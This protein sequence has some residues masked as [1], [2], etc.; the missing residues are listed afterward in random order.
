MAK[1]PIVSRQVRDAP[2]PGVRR[3]ATASPEAMG[4]GLGR[5]VQ[6]A[7][8]V[9]L[10]IHQDEQ[11]KAEQVRLF[12]LKRKLGEFENR[13]LYDAQNGALNARGEDAFGLPDQVLGD[14][15]T[16]VGE[17]SQG[18]GS[19]RL[20]QSFQE[21]AAGQRQGIDRTLQRHVG[22]EIQRHEAQTVEAVIANAQEAAAF[23][24][25]DPERVLDEID[26]QRAAII[27]QA[28]RN[29]LPGDWVKLKT[30]HAASATHIGVIS[31]MVSAGQD[32]EAQAYFDRFGDDIL[33]QG[34]QR[35]KAQD[36]IRRGN[37]LGT[38]QRIADDMLD[39]HDEGFGVGL[40][41]QEIR[42]MDLEPGA[43]AA[44]EQHVR[45]AFARRE[46]DRNQFREE[47]AN[48]IM[49]VLEEN[50][51]DMRVI[52][53]GLWDNLLPAQ[54]RGIERS[55]QEMTAPPEFKEGSANIAALDAVRQAIDIGRLQDPNTGA[56]LPV[57]KPWI[58]AQA[59]EH[60]MTTG[61]LKQA[62]EYFDQRGQEGELKR[63][64]VSG[65]VKALTGDALE[66]VIDDYPNLFEEIRGRLEPGK[67]V[68]DE[69]VRKALAPLLL[70][71]SVRGEWRDKTFLDAKNRDVA[72]QWLPNLSDTEELA[73]A[74]MFNDN[75]LPIDG[76]KTVLRRFRKYAPVEQGGLGL[77][78]PIVEG[79]AL[80]LKDVLFRGLDTK[81]RGG[82]GGSTSFIREDF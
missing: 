1:V 14:Y 51:G 65:V 72:D 56:V 33:T 41:M 57:S 79:Q 61:Q 11:R 45:Q 52:P 60:G 46:Q 18:L 77:P 43:R 49:T 37:Q 15:D 3:T 12:D 2:L 31:R 25:T 39:K 78:T 19:E 29:G 42:A 40:A 54:R 38:A 5:E 9:A 62:L 7:G 24:Y 10:E 48:E 16:F 34:G 71:G 53:P 50:G 8:D 21:L 64:Q 66:D 22:Q 69:A 55:V 82:A 36:M 32:R 26:I 67:P 70:K 28:D 23:N 59:A 68:T 4:A 44:A 81:R 6:R 80:P 74:Q 27:A 73:L 17:L 30:Q 13:R 76:D 20:R 63:A 75:G 47:A 58:Y 35:D